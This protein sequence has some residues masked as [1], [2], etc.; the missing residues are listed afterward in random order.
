MEKPVYVVCVFTAHR[1]PAS[2]FSQLT[3]SPRP[4]IL[5][6][7]GPHP[8]LLP[9]AL[10]VR[11]FAFPFPSILFLNTQRGSDPLRSEI[12]LST[13]LSLELTLSLAFLLPVLGPSEMAATR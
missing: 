11:T 6:F 3:C 13:G 8:D 5:C 9:L 12:I 1:S 10:L 4:L 2:S 7:P